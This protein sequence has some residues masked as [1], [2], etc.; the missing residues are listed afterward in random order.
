VNKEQFTRN[1]MATTRPP[2]PNTGNY[3]S[4]IKPITNKPTGTG[5]NLTGS[6]GGGGGSTSTPDAH[7]GSDNNPDYFDGRSGLYYDP[8]ADNPVT[9]PTPVD[10]TPV[11]PNKAFEDAYQRALG[12]G[13]QQVA[14]R[15]YQQPLVDKYGILTAYKEMIDRQ[16]GTI[17]PTH[18]DPYQLYSRDAFFNDAVTDA[19]GRYRA[20][21]RNNLNSQY[22]EGFEMQAFGDTA[23]DALLQDIL[24]QQRADAQLTIDRSRAR[25]SLNDSGYTRANKAIEDQNAAGMSTI[26]SLGGGV[27]ADYRKQLGDTRSNALNRINTADFTNGYNVDSVLGQLGELRSKFQTNMGN[28]IQRAVGG[29]SFFDPSVAISRG[30]QTQGTINPSRVN[31]E[32][33]PLFAAFQAEDRKK[34]FG[35]NTGSTATTGAF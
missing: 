10:P 4:N 20:D 35:N 26:Q 29:T 7:G 25:G 22:G 11:D 2:G 24:N 3:V 13:N 14:T 16:K 18:S 17:D 5:N 30:G 32:G 15:G 27:L 33:N 19:T 28:D 23:D 21:M 8:L 6:F 34:T 1:I 9:P 12:Y 31:P